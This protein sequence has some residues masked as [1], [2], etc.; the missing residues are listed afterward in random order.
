[1]KLLLLFAFLFPLKSAAQL[2]D[3]IYN[4]IFDRRF[5]TISFHQISTYKIKCIKYTYN[6]IVLKPAK[7]NEGKIVRT[8]DTIPKYHFESFDSLGM[9][10]H[11]SSKSCL[12][13]KAQGNVPYYSQPTL[14]FINL[15]K[16]KKGLESK[17]FYFHDSI[18]KVF[19]VF[20]DS[21][22]AITIYNFSSWGNLLP[23]DYLQTASSLNESIKEIAVPWTF[24]ID[25]HYNLVKD[26]LSSNLS[27]STGCGSNILVSYY[28]YNAKG[29]VI[30]KE[31]TKSST[32]QILYDD[33]GRVDKI[34]SYGYPIANFHYE[35]ERLKF[36]KFNSKR[37]LNLI[38]IEY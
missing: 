1:M 27:K 12:Q 7:N 17:R 6:H 3:E 34:L 14:D 36:V 32:I 33:Q 4:E 19:A 24:F 8:Y 30:K 5:E 21:L 11:S 22:N 31:S 2:V 26:S 15:L 10:I 25:E 9:L 16:E 18:A 28:K 35:K 23:K 38:E 29:Q 13:Q 37:G 20:N